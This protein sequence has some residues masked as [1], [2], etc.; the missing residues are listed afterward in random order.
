MVDTEAEAV[1]FVNEAA[2]A[3]R[4]VDEAASTTFVAEVSV[5]VAVATRFDSA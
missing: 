3:T 5:F 1:A 4:F 2:S